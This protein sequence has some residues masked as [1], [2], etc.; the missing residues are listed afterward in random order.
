MAKQTGGQLISGDEM[1]DFFIEIKPPFEIRPVLRKRK[2]Y[3]SETVAREGKTLSVVINANFYDLSGFGALSA[4]SGHPRLDPD[5]TTVQGIVVHNK[6]VIAGTKR[7]QDF[8]IA[9]YKEKAVSGDLTQAFV[10]GKGDP[11]TDSSVGLSGLGPLIINGLAYGSRNQYL[12]GTA[13]NAPPIGEP[14]EFASSLRQRSSAKFT[15]FAKR[16]ADEE[17]QLGK[18]C[19]GVSANRLFIYVQAHGTPGKSIGDVRDKFIAQGCKHAVFFDGSDSAM[20]FQNGQFKVSQGEDKDETCVIGLG[21]KYD[22]GS[23]R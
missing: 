12:A 10:S 14:G 21:F 19:L 18:T 13:A 16:D 5:N 3:F 11:P 1:S 8:F 9:Y 22:D 6:T 15:A 20:L 7:P 17:F 2:E 23:K 4:L